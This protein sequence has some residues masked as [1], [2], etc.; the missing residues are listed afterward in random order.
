MT[1]EHGTRA[2]G[3]LTYMCPA[4]VLVS[5]PLIVQ[6]PMRT[7][8]SS[9]GCVG[10]VISTMLSPLFPS[11]I[12]NSLTSLTPCCVREC[13][14]ASVDGWCIMYGVSMLLYFTRPPTL[15]VLLYGWSYVA[16]VKHNALLRV[17]SCLCVYCCVYDLLLHVW[18][19]Q[20][21]VRLAVKHD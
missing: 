11:S 16:C 18:V 20:A 1:V 3:L 8:E 6:R 19:R 5:M 21:C 2:S 14:L 17:W 7:Y 4:L 12:S 9:W 15:F 10:C 13:C